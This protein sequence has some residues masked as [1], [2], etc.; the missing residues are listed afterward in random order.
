M[1]ICTAA[2]TMVAREE[3]LELVRPP[4]AAWVG[5]ALRASLISIRIGIS[6]PLTEIVVG[7]L[8]GNLDNYFGST[9][10]HSNSWLSFRPGF[11]SMMPTFL[12]GA[13]IEPQTFR[14]YLFPSLTMGS[15]HRPFHKSVS[16]MPGICVLGE[17]LEPAGFPNSGDLAV[18]VFAKRN[19]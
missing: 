3:T 14:K 4:A 5:Q 11:V 13:E 19:S 10:F 18:R 12:T 6:A 7:I 17:R 9:L 8:A 15:G 2:C 16:G 1:L